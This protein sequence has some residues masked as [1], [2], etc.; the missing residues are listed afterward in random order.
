[1][2][3]L[4]FTSKNSIG[5]TYSSLLNK[6]KTYQWVVDIIKIT[7]LSL[8]VIF[9]VVVY[10]YF[11]NKSST[12]WYFLRQAT[13]DLNAIKF[14]HEIVKTKVLTHKQRNRQQMHDSFGTNDRVVNIHATIAANSS[15]ELSLR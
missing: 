3:T 1:M 13:N 9:F 10:L 4:A 7:L 14:Q 5:Q 11:V 6:Y 15:P 8:S 12:Q 2:K